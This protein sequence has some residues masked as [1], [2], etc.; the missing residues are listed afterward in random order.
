MKNNDILDFRR[1]LLSWFEKY[2][3]DLPWRRTRDPYRIWVSEVMLQQTRVNTVIP[4]YRDFIDRFPDIRALATADLAEVLK[5][6]EGL[7]YY[8]RARNLHDAARNIVAKMNGNL[9]A[10]YEKLRELQGIGDYIASAVAS[11]AFDL[12]YPVVDG[13]VKRVL[14]RLYRIDSPVSSART[15]KVFREKARNL[16]DPG[17]PR[18][19]NQ[20]MMELGALTC[21]PREPDC[22]E[23]PVADH[24]GAYRLGLQGDYP[25]RLPKKLVPKHR[26]V[27]GVIYHGN[28]FLITRRDPSGL[29][30]GLWEFP[31]GRIEDGE[32]AEEAL[33]REIREEVGI[34]I[35]IERHLTRVRHAYSHFRIVMDIF[36]CR[37]RAGEV[38]LK[39]PIDHRWI[40]VREIEDYAFPAANHKFIPLM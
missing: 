12:P 10:D 24:C 5:C 8:A 28:R 23:C 27:T 3:R 33:N 17:E 36:V 6:W 29:L 40:T 11:L 21:R 16:L 26:V 30:G 13:N 18:Q 9:P 39:G 34:S 37:Y 20:A 31:G 22:S 19:F 32:S 14:A 38:V 7:G 4:Y 1:A 15:M 2:G 35:E 25:I